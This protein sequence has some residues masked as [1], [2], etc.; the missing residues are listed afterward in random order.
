MFFIFAQMDLFQIRFTTI[1]LFIF[2]AGAALLPTSEPE[3]EPDPDPDPELEPDPVPEPEPCE[4][5]RPR[6]AAAGT[7]QEA[8]LVECWRMKSVYVEVYLWNKSRPDP[9]QRD[10]LEVGPLNQNRSRVSH[11]EPRSRPGYSA[12]SEPELSANRVRTCLQGPGSVPELW[13]NPSGLNRAERT[14]RIRTT[15]QSSASSNRTDQNLSSWVLIQ[16]S[17]VGPDSTWWMLFPPHRCWPGSGMSAMPPAPPVVTWR[18]QL[19]SGIGSEPA[20]VRTLN[21]KEHR[22]SGNRTGTCLSLCLS[23]SCWVLVTQTWARRVPGVNEAS[24]PQQE[25]SVWSKQ[26]TGP[27]RDTPGRSPVPVLLPVNTQS[28]ELSLSPIMHCSGSRRVSVC[29]ERFCWCW[30]GLEVEQEEVEEVEQVACSSETK[31]RGHQEDEEA[32]AA[33]VEEMKAEEDPLSAPLHIIKYVYLLL[34]RTF[35]I[36]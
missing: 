9:K 29:R 24:E 21:T 36:N 33:A 7:E 13:N 20:A 16:T 6:A 10:N 5:P 8:V 2:I 30:T 28:A 23:S 22:S 18:Q 11:T 3:P 31:T 35:S 4:V 26:V 15:A 27:G 32:A 19:G 17:G 1:K 12:E 14:L 25:A 34:Q